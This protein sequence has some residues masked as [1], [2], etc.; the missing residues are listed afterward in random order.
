MTS[1]RPQR[2]KLR[3]RIL[4]KINTRINKLV[5]LTPALHKLTHRCKFIAKIGYDGVVEVCLYTD[6]SEVRVEPSKRMYVSNKALYAKQSYWGYVEIT[7][8]STAIGGFKCT[9]VRERSIKQSHTFAAD[10]LLMVFPVSCGG[11]YN[12]YDVD[13][14][15]QDY[16]EF[17][18][19]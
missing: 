13:Q 15:F 10:Y 16:R 18:L 17:E 8:D 3:S 11:L 6:V 5:T 19:T 2:Q 9:F 12:A 4:S 14:M 1:T 7:K